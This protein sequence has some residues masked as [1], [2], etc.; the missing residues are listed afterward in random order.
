MHIPSL[1]IPQGIP[2]SVWLGMG[3]LV[4]VMA[5]GSMMQRGTRYA[6]PALMIALAGGLIYGFIKL[7]SWMQHVQDKINH[8]T[9]SAKAP[10]KIG[11]TVLSGH[12]NL[13]TFNMNATNP[14]AHQSPAV[15]SA[16]ILIAILLVIGYI[17][18]RVISPVTTPP[19]FR[20][21]ESSLQRLF[22]QI[23]LL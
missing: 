10:I 2:M 7:R 12:D 1:F 3:L 8:P 14:F 21:G 17:L 20:Y 15:L 6:S 11:N 22:S 16:A 18:Y 13:P 5:L 19:A 4:T 9:A 23:L